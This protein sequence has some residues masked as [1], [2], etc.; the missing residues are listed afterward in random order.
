LDQLLIK[1]MQNIENVDFQMLVAVGLESLV[2]EVVFILR[3]DFVLELD[4]L[5]VELAVVLFFIKMNFVLLF[6]SDLVDF[7]LGEE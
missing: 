6:D 2:V 7:E 5:L 1:P 4:L 3:K